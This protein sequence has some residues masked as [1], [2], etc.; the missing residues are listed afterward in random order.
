M[1]EMKCFETHSVNMIELAQLCGQQVNVISRPR[2][3]RLWHSLSHP[4]C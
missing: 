4:N 1:T 2:S 3:E